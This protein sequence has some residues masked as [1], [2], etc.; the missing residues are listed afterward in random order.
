M[1]G[2]VSYGAYIPMYRLAR[3]EIARAW[4]GGARD[5]EKAVANWDED[6]LTMGVEAAIDCLSGMEREAVDGLYFAS[7]TPPYREK[8]SASIISYAADL[9]KDISTAD[10]AASLRGGASAFRAA[11]DAISAGSANR[12]LVVA[13]DSRLPAPSSEFEPVFGDGAAALLLGDSDVIASVEGSYTLTS[14]FIG[15]WRRENDTYSRTWETRFVITHGYQELTKKAIDG[16]LQKY[17]LKPA[18][19]SKIAVYGPEARSHAALVRSVGFDPNTQA[20]DPLLNNVGNTGTASAMMILVAALE[21]AK[22]GDRILWASYGD[23]ADAFVLK[24]E[25][26]I[27][28]LGE[29][30][31][32]KHHLASKAMLSNYEKY[33]R[34]RNLLEWEP[35]RRPPTEGSLEIL[36]RESDNLLRGRAQKCLT[37]G[38]VQFPVQRIC[39]WCQTKDN[40]EWVRIADK[41]GI[42]F[43]F[44]MDER[45]MVPILPNVLCAIDMKIDDENETRYFGQMTDRDPEKI[46]VGMPVELTFRLINEAA[47]VKNYSWKI[48]P[49]R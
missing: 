20:Q 14:D 49:L 2:I 18:D 8:Q 26:N 1:A 31:G 43:T 39:M 10:I 33:L 13:S 6:S 45:A 17:N 25:D 22:P 44:S 5:G 30:Q 46:E 41:K 11:S 12:M 32:I 36:W 15:V 28:K 9:R 23:G 7:T 34:F 37:C 21:E 3:S 27:N 4:E 42:I 16:L 47:G 29:R 48:R 24:V 19:F 40:F 38:H 35:E